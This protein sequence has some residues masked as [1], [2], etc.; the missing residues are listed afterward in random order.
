MTP[1]LSRSLLR[2]KPVVV[3][4]ALV[5][6]ADAKARP[7]GRAFEVSKEVSLPSWGVRI[8]GPGESRCSTQIP[9]LALVRPHR[10]AVIGV[11]PVG[12][13]RRPDL[14]IRLRQVMAAGLGERRCFTSACLAVA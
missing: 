13:G 11:A 5:V 1:H 10:V 6:A 8:L 2:P 14:P 12:D 4:L 7:G 9:A 3:A